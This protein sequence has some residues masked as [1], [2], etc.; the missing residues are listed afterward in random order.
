MSWKRS[1]SS[2]Q[3]NPSRPRRCCS[4]AWETKNHCLSALW[5]ASVVSAFGKR[6]CM[7]LSVWLS[8]PFSATRAIPSW[9]SAK[10]SPPSFVLFCWHMTL[11]HGYKKRDWPSHLLWRSGSS[12]R[13]R[14]F[15]M[16]RSPELKKQFNT[17]QRVSKP[18][19]PRH[20]D[21]QNSHIG[22]VHE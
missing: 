9:P 15:S 5:S 11:S 6:P 20:T 17:H 7:A 18:G 13:D 19:A 10:S 4:S 3:K 12:K 1:A 16:K 8:L 21:G 2:H 14:H 22:K